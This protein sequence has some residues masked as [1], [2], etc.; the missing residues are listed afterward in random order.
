[1]EQNKDKRFFFFLHYFD[2]HD[3]YVPP[4]PFASEFPSNPYAGEIAYTDHCIGQVLEKL[5]KL[6]L[7]DSTLIIITSDHGEMLGEHGEDTHTYFIYQAAI[8]VPLIFKLPGQSKP[9]RIKAIAGLVD[10]VPTVCNALGIETPKNVQGVDLFADSNGKN[11]SVEN[12]HIYCESLLPTRYKASPLLGVVNDRYKYIQTTRPELYDLIHDP[13]ESTDLSGNQ[14]QLAGVMKDKL[15]QI[16]EQFVRKASPDSRM[17][18]DTRTAERLR[19]LGYV[20]GHVTE[21]FSV[22]Q[23]KDDPKDLLG[24]HLLN[25]RLENHR[26]RRE[27][28]D[29]AVILAEQMIQQ[30]PDLSPAYEALGLIALDQGDYSGAIVH[31]GKAIEVGL[32]NARTAIVYNNRGA[33]YRKKGE[34][35]LAIHDFNEAIRLSPCSA[36]AHSNRGIAY[37]SKG[38][39][40]QGISDLDRAIELNPNNAKS[41]FNRGIAYQGKGNLVRA[42]R[43]FNKAITLNPALKELLQRP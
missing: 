2:P 36:E 12:R 37:C 4:E 26:L 32:D 27:K 8:K 38:E 28:Y 14:Q 11:P 24:Y 10:I 43:D 17:E 21:D 40:E 29:Q 35:D 20:G 22:D 16:L 42:D 1:M 33:A 34:Y 39:Y 5:K 7:Y 18:V 30:R 41:Y 23:T 3:E 13:A 15:A 19:S 25:V 31:L 9:A 6:G